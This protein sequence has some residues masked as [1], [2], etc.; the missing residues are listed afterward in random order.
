MEQKCGKMDQTW[1]QRIPWAKMDH[2][3]LNGLDTGPNGLEIEEIPSILASSFVSTF[4]NI[5]GTEMQQD[6][7][8]MAPKRP[9]GPKEARY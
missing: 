8:D 1:S 2:M 6:G 3:G 9:Y 5:N 7:P 4:L